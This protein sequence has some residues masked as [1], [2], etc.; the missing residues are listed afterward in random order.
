MSNE[1]IKWNTNNM[2]NGYP[3][4]CDTNLLKEVVQDLNDEY[5]TK[6]NGGKNNSFWESII[7]QQLYVGNNELRLR[8]QGK[9]GH[10]W[11]SMNNPFVYVSVIVILAFLAYLAYTLEWPLRFGSN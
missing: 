1:R 3:K 4:N 6:K 9:S 10:S 2:P 8:T 7:K 11:F 5:V